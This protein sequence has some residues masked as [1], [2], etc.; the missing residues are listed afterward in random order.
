MP[1]GGARTGAGRKKQERPVDGNLARK[2]KVK[3]NAEEKWI[4]VISL[5]TTKAV[6]TGHT[7]DLRHALE[8]L[9]NRDLGNT[10]DTVNH[11]HDKPL[12]VNMTVSLAEAIQ[13]ARKRVAK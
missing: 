7:S 8:Y 6:Q 4:L 2:I 11:L 1:R 12:E 13:K 5:A 3:I 9:D 10:M